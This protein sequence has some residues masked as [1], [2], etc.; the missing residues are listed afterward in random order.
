MKQKML[1]ENQAEWLE[2]RKGYVTS[3]EVAALFG[4]GQW[5]TAFEL[6]HVKRGTLEKEVQDNDFLAFG[7]F[8]EEAIAKMIEFKNPSWK[9]EPFN[10]FVYDDEIKIGSSFDRTIIIDGKKY[11]LEIKTTTFKEFKK[12]FT[13][14]E[15]SEQYEV[16]VQVELEMAEEFSGCLLA[17]FLLDTREL[18]LYFRAK[19]NEVCEAIKTKVKQFWAS[20]EPPALEYEHDKS[21][22]AKVAPKANAD[23]TMNAEENTEFKELAA[24]YLSAKEILKSTETEAD[25]CYTRLME[26]M[27]DNKTAWSNSYRVTATDVKPTEGKLITQEMVGTFTGARAGYKRLTV[28]ELNK[29]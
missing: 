11:L 28:T 13:E 1:I 24:R 22:L 26:I 27:Q 6:W 4:L 15:A 25:Y 12:H 2:K 18:K 16:Q 14:E 8:A 5:M 20:T 29:E 17:V 3:T 7:R 10:Y 19:D 23:K 21:V 9:I